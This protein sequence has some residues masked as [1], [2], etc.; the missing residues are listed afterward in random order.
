MAK[1]T[2]NCYSGRFSDIATSLQDECG[3]NLPWCV[4][5]MYSK[6]LV[7]TVLSFIFWAM[8]GQS[9]GAQLWSTQLGIGTKHMRE[10]E[11]APRQRIVI[12]IPEV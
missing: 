5:V 2:Q 4:A 9:Q 11:R 3:R 12:S 7:K 1:E 6:Y 8:G 10:T